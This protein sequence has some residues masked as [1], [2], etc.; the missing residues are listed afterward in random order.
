MRLPALL[1]FCLLVF[2]SLLSAGTYNTFRAMSLLPLHHALIPAPLTPET[3]DLESS[4]PTQKKSV[5]QSL[6]TGWKLHT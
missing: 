2:L 3:T 1:Q 5:D 6:R 4:C